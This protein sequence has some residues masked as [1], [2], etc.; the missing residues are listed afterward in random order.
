[1]ASGEYRITVDPLG[2]VVDCREGQT[3]LEALREAGIGLESVCGGQGRCGKCR[4]RVLA[5]DAGEPADDERSL[6]PGGWRE[7]GLRLACRVIPRQDLTVY[8]PA[9]TLTASGRLQLE[10]ALRPGER[11]PA[12]QAYDV[13][14]ELPSQPGDAGSDLLRLRASLLRVAPKA[15]P[16]N[17]DIEALRALPRMLR[18]EGGAVRALLRG[19]TVLGIIPRKRSPLGAAVDLGSTKIALFLY[20]LES[21]EMLSA[22][23]ML[24]P[25]I[26][27]GE[28]VVTRIQYASQGGARR[29]RE[30][31]VE[32]IGRELD[33]MAAGAARTRDGIFEMV[34]VGNTAM[35]HLFTGLP[36]EQL[37]KSP[38]LPAT[39]L[40]LEVTARDLGLALNPSAVVYLPPP[41]AGYVGSDHLAALSAARLEERKGP[42]LLLDIGTNTEV[43]LQVEGRIRCCSCAS[44]PAFEGGGLS[45]GMRAG[46]GAV[47]AVSIDPRTGEPELKVIGE[48][49]PAGICGSGVLSMLAELVRTGTVDEGGRLAEKSH[50]VTR[51]DGGLSFTLSPGGEE[52]EPLA[53]TQGDI[54]E[55]QKAKGAMRAGID[56]LL[57]EAG[58]APGDLREVILA[59]AFGTYIDPQDALDIALLPPVPLEAVVQVGNAA[60]AGARSM[61]LASGARREAEA[62]AERIEYLEL[63]A[64]PRLGPLFAAGMFLTEEAVAE[65]KRRFR[66]A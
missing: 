27:Y 47:E 15:E 21:G 5:G 63:S 48:G 24:N 57:A 28:D 26:P 46:E 18:E 29:L 44:G 25:Q 4:V 59:G 34:V 8:L 13:E 51:R 11:D 50:G 7:K 53:V 61:L 41:V 2:R 17:I 49:P 38:Y 60:G 22:R 35:H 65:A 52:R 16:E 10:S 3:L 54:R 37:G 1:M 23:G 12:V 40:P 56:A 19:R 43:A 45:C 36:V 66:L 64:Y 58:L 30:L 55:I 20:D 6:L 32:G 31:V 14:V 42:S 39:D 9:S 33:G 62:M